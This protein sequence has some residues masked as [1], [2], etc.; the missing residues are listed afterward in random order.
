MNLHDT[1]SRYVEWRRTHGADFKSGERLLRQFAST[2]GAQTDCDSVS[3]AQVRHF[4]EGN[5][6][7]T[8]SRSNRYS[9]V[10]GFYRYAIS[11]NFATRLPLPPSEEEPR[12]PKSA[13]PYVYSKQEVQWLFKAIDVCHNPRS[14]LDA[15]TFR[16]L[17]LLLYGAGLRTC[18]ALRL[19]LADVNLADRVMTVRDSKFHKSRLV[20]VESDLCEAL[21]RYRKIRMKRPLSNGIDGS[22]FLACLNGSALTHQTAHRAFVRLRE[23]VGLDSANEGHLRPSLHSWR[24]TFATH[25]LTSWYQQGADV[26]RLL[27]ALSTYLGHKSLSGTQV[28]LSM[29]PELLQEA[30][31]MFD[32]YINGDQK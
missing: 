12:R 6:Q 24:H 22:T 32:N 3:K 16:M 26:Q 18:E 10:S 8:S 21:C 25:R 19:T 31:I 17:L 2:I 11:R 4:L 9:A 20:P 5:R 1:I 13:L 15:D 7:L 28:Y 30:S 14:S 29:T 23:F 27:P